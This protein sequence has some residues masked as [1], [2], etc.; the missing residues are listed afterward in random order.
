MKK[1]FKNTKTAK[2]YINDEY[3]AKHLSR[4]IDLKDE[5]SIMDIMQDFSDFNIKKSKAPEMLEML[6]SIVHLFKR[7]E[8]DTDQNIGGRLLIQAEEL[9][10]ETTT[11]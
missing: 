4:A 8:Y 6:N 3:G 11:I 9:I 2:E 1:T 10:K 7:G 5:V